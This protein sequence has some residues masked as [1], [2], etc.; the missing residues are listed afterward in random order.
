MPSYFFD[1]SAVVKAYIREPGSRWVRQILRGKRVV[2]FV[3]PI[4]GVEVVAAL[5]RKERTGEIDRA[6]RERVVGAFRA[7]FRRRLTHT[8]LTAAVI[9]EAMILVLAHPL[10]AYDAMQLASAVQLRGISGP[11]RPLSFVSADLLLLRIARERG[12]S[13]ENPMDHP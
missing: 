3:S 1:A 7:D 8:A 9:E 6:A 10:R 12:L 2:A 4:S 13:A 11:L 5:A